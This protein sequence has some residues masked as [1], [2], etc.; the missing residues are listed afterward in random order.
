MIL[1]T[2]LAIAILI[3]AISVILSLLVGGSTLIFVFGDV[4]ICI[5]IIILLCKAIF[6]RKK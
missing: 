4:I 5:L 6:G 3:L 1:F 2:S